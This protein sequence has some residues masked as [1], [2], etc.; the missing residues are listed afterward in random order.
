VTLI[1]IAEIRA[2]ILRPLIGF[3]QQHLSGRVAIQFR[4]DTL[5]DG[6]RLL[7][8][9]V[10]GPFAPAKMYGVQPEA[11]DAEIEPAPT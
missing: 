9:L 3:G 6:V 4:A 8:V 2:D 11:I 5:D 7:E 10:G 1:A